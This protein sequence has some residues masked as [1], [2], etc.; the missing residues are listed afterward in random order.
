MELGVGDFAIESQPLVSLSAPGGG[1]DA[2]ALDRIYTLGAERSIYQDAAFGLRQ[3][4]DVAVRALSPGV[5]DPSTAAMC[6]DHLG[7]LVACLARRRMP[8][9]LR[10]ERGELRVIGCAP[11]FEEL[12]AIA[13]EPLLRNARGEPQ[14]LA[15]LERGARAVAAA[16]PPRRAS[17]IRGYLEAIEAQRA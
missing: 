1:G 13:F 6:A 5:N 12:A 11:G 17:V 10:A 8:E 7:A 16:A 4:T 9:R 15:A 2:A 3:I 14:V